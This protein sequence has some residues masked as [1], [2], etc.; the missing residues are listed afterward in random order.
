MSESTNRHRMQVP[1][2]LALAAS[3]ASRSAI[4][5]SGRSGGTT[6]P[7]RVLTRLRPD[8]IER[9][10][11]SLTGG[12]I[13]V[14]STNGKTTTASM[15]GSILEAD[16]RE[17]LH[18]RA[19]SNMHWGI[20]TTLLDSPGQSPGT[21][22]LFEID[23]AWVSRLAPVLNPK[24]VVLGNLF[25]DQLD[26]Y[27][28]LER[29]AEDWA[30]MVS[31]LPSDCTLVLCAD[32]PAIASLADSLDPDGEVVFF[33]MEDES[34]ALAQEAHAFD[35][36]NCR[37][38][39]TRYDYARTFLGHLGHYRCP[40]CGSSRPAEVQ[41]RATRVQLHG[42]EGSVMD[43]ETPQG[44]VRV[45][46]GLPGLY[47]A[48]NALAAVAVGC[49]AG[50]GLSEIRTGIESSPAVFGRSERIRLDDGELSM[51][52]IKNPTGANEVLRTLADEASRSGPL[53]LWLGLNDRIADGR[54]V[55]WIWDAD[56][57][58][59]AQSVGKVTCS[60]TRAPEMALRLKYAQ[61]PKESIIVDD[62]L[63]RSLR[64]AVGESAGRLFAMPT[65][66]AMLEVRGAIAGKGQADDFWV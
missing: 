28:E 41:I 34:N 5:A 47:N 1:W 65:Y 48:Y 18:N 25:R 58:V 32:D 66:T 49:S 30:D 4:R 29:L 10:A 53:D 43:V 40:G 62:D 13:I 33:G 51:L 24:V 2:S 45:E 64:T 35:T 36:S 38:C 56:F 23:E 42:F 63:E 44:E 27:G 31:R 11:S 12:S 21:I 26:R 14:S 59:L 3:R 17:I 37:K 6:L 22:G 20:A 16:S 8:A 50:I 7:G 54:D 46:I 19:G 39:G 57:E 52:L 60:G 55:S 15:I 9:L 61:W